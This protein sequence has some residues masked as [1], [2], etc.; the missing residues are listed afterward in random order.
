MM[1][2]EICTV[3]GISLR[4][5]LALGVVVMCLCLVGCTPQDNFEIAIRNRLTQA[6]EV[7]ACENEHLGDNLLTSFETV[8][9][10]QIEVLI[11]IAMNRLLYSRSSPLQDDGLRIIDV[12][13]KPELLAVDIL[14]KTGDRKAIRPLLALLS[15]DDLMRFERYCIGRALCR[16]GDARGIPLVLDYGYK[17]CVPCLELKHSYA[18]GTT[19]SDLPL[20]T[21]D[22][23]LVLSLGADAISVL[24]DCLYRPRQYE[25]RGLGWPA[26][27]FPH[28]Y[29]R[30]ALRAVVL[31]K[32]LRAFDILR[33]ARLKVPLILRAEIDRALHDGLGGSTKVREK[34]VRRK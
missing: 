9:D 20:S 22:Q 25:L 8:N 29:I 1:I 32:E 26:L 34:V 23:S 33:K 11:G 3:C 17:Y 21:S 30:R 27:R 5:L 14:G 2:A 28:Y 7:Y 15:D 12:T 19:R 24:E 31:L 10:R 18:W 13:P 6:S 4:R 16:L